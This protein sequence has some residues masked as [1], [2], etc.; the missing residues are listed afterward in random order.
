MIF[1]VSKRNAQAILFWILSVFSSHLT[2]L[3]DRRLYAG[4]SNNSLFWSSRTFTV[5]SRNWHWC[6]WLAC[7]S[8]SK[9][10]LWAILETAKVTNYEISDW[11]LPKHSKRNCPWMLRREYCGGSS[12]FVIAKKGLDNS[13]EIKTSQIRVITN[14][15]LLWLAQK[16]AHWRN[17]TKLLKEFS[18][19][20]DLISGTC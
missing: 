15:K 5:A 16:T 4:S 19:T 11:Q 1:F 9:T 20:R 17:V 12:V 18:L 14:S 2:W 13:L 3:V 7:V 8:K 10:K 6:I